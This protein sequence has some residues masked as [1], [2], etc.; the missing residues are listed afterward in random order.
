MSK[1]YWKDDLQ[2]MLH[3]EFTNFLKSHQLNNVIN[4]KIKNNI[5]DNPE[6]KNLIEELDSYILNGIIKI[7]DT[8]ENKFN[9]LLNNPDLLINNKIQEL[10]SSTNKKILLSFFGGLFVSFFLLK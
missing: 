5:K 4:E 1:F 2:P 6:Y 8:T 3:F 10:E 7:Q 9:E